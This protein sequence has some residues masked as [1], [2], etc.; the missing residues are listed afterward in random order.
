MKTKDLTQMTLWLAI[1][2]VLAYMPVLPVPFLPVPI[3]I[4]NMVFMVMGAFLGAKKGFL[5]ALLYLLIYATGILGKGGLAV[6]LSASGGYLFSYP[7]AVLAVGYFVE[8]YWEQLSDLKLLLILIGFGVIFINLSGALF[9][10]Y[11]LHLGNLLPV[12]MSCLVYLPGDVIKAILAFFL[13]KRLKNF[14]LL[15]K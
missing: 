3:V 5:T 8:R 15:A 1:T 2:I 11:Y 6:F 12:L 14:S 10:V 13:F 7:F 4:Q 9:M